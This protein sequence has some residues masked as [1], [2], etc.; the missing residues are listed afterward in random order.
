MKI[1]IVT[2]ASALIGGGHVMRC[3]TLAA[4]ARDSGCDV[5]FCVNREAF[6]A[7]PRL[8]AAGFETLIADDP[9]SS[10][11]L[12]VAPS[13]LV[14]VDSYRSDRH[15]ERALRDKTGSIAVIDDLAERVHDCD[16]LIDTTWG[17][18]VSDYEGLVPKR[19]TVLAGASYALLR[20]EFVQARRAALDA[21]AGRS[22]RLRCLIS[23][24]LTDVGGITAAIVRAL[25]ASESNFL[26]DV[27]VGPNA[28]SLMELRHLADTFGHVSLHVDVTNMAALMADADVAVG[29]GGSTSWERCCLGLP[30]VMVVVADNQHLVA[31]SLA[32]AGAVVVVECGAD[33]DARAVNALASLS[34]DDLHR[35]S[36]AAAAV[37]D[38]HGAARVWSGLR[39]LV[40]G[41]GAGCLAQTHDDSV[42]N[43]RSAQPADADQLWQ[44]RNDKVSRANSL[45]SRIVP[46]PEHLKWFAGVLADR[47]RHLLVAECHDVPVGMIR[48]DAVD[49]EKGEELFAISFLVAPDWRGRGIGA[50]VLEAGCRHVRSRRPDARLFGQVRS[51]NAASRRLFERLGFSAQHDALSDDVVCYSLDGSRP[52]DG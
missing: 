41:G 16:L 49:G 6:T 8:A 12:Q 39:H 29:A 52:H 17:R 2:E 40:E 14:I 50:Q 23:L 5:T 31:S 25:L 47:H 34:R 32:E 7:V 36:A 20:P 28:P 1:T 30:T 46:W 43:L 51:D 18:A 45:D 27:V 44:W 24:G 26:L 35:M 21:R 9:V 37:T 15:F 13:D 22:G 4:V 3:L 33:Q 11:G 19:A 48:F 42:L 38:G 10:R